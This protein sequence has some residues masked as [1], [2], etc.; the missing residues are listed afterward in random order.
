[1]NP[2]SYYGDSYPAKFDDVTASK[3]IHEYSGPGDVVLDPF[4][5][6]GVIP[7]EAIKLER[8]A[9]AIDINPVAVEIMQQHASNLSESYKKLGMLSILCGDARTQL[10]SIKENSIRL[11]LTS[12]TFGLSIDAA[13]D[14]YSDLKGDMGNASTYEKW[15]EMLS[16]VIAKIYHVTEANGLLMIEIR[17]RSED[18]Q[19][20][21]LWNWITNDAIAAGFEY[22]GKFI[23]YP[24]PTFMLYT[25]G[26]KNGR[27]PIPYHSEILIFS[28][29]E[30]YKLMGGLS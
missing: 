2:R 23:E 20:R 4:S 11:T 19:P 13:H 7:L 26:P 9:V 30:N 24:V 18:K 3:L 21:P 8:N 16:E 14:S 29:P 6:S 22:F 17:E 10:D 25:T 27:R 1:M 28:K 12:P 5:G 15:N